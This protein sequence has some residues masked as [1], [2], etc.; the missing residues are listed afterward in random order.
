SSESSWACRGYDLP[1]LSRR[2]LPTSIGK[3]ASL[4]SAATAFEQMALDREIT[5]GLA[6]YLTGHASTVRR[7]VYS[8]RKI[9]EIARAVEN[10]PT[11]FSPV[12]HARDKGTHLDSARGRSWKCQRG[13]RPIESVLAE[14]VPVKS[15]WS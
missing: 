9:D 8:H 5:E 7:R 2:L 4:C 11:P 15:S 13:I 14:L 10:L 1:K 3:M 12:Q 6:E